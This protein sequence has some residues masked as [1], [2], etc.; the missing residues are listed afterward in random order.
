MTQF[1][2]RRYPRHLLQKC[3]E[4]ATNTK[5]KPIRQGTDKVIFITQFH[6]GLGNIKD[7][8]QKHQ[9]I[10]SQHPDTA[11]LTRKQF[12]VAYRRPTNI[13]NILVK[14]DLKKSTSQPG[15]QPCGKI[16]CRTCKFMYKTK[17]F[18]SSITNIEYQIK[19]RFN[20]Q[21]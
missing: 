9:Q 5:D 7:I 3:I 6:P 16:R 1:E 18:T 10:L 21:I 11:F 13:R 8:W 14:T 20:C 4:K 12:M 17:T 15:N 2:K 19:G